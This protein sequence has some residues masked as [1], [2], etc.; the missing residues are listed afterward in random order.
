[1]GVYALDIKI[2]SVSNDNNSYDVQSTA[3]HVNEQ[4]NSFNQFDDKK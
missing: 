3:E 4:E 1:M 2:I